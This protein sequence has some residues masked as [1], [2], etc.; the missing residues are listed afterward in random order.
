MTMIKYHKKSG[1]IATLNVY[2]HTGENFKSSLEFD[3]NNTLKKFM[4]LKTNKEIV[5]VEKVKEGKVR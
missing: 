4:E 1:S 3:Q 5:S 2:K